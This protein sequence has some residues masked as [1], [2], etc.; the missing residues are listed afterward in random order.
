M[1]IIEIG[2]RLLALILL[3]CQVCHR[4][5]SAMSSS[6]VKLTREE[7]Y[8]QIWTT[9]ARVLAEQFDISDVGLAKACKRMGIP[10]PPRGYWRRKETGKQVKTIPL[11]PA[12]PTDKLTV[13][14]YRASHPKRPTTPRRDL[15][16]AE[17]FQSFDQPHPLVDLT[18]RRFENATVSKSGLLVS[19]AKQRLDLTVS[20]D[21]LERALRLYDAILKA[22]ERQGNEVIIGKEDS[23]LTLLRSGTETLR[24]SIEEEVETVTLPPTET[25]L[26]KPKWTWKLRTETRGKGSLKILLRGDQIEEWRSFERRFRDGAAS[27]LENTVNR[28]LTVALDYPTDRRDYL[29]DAE[30]KRKELEEHR[31]IEQLR[32]QREEEER[33]RREAERKRVEAFFGAASEWEESSRLRAFIAECRKRMTDSGI[34][35][36]VIREW[37]AWAEG[38]ADEHDPFVDGYPGDFPAEESKTN[39]D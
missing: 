32:R 15:I 35:V 23:S 6:T 10:R 30:R 8:K 24:I 18:R 13:E 28:I 9:P 33:F 27:S 39:D 29:V 26:L 20:R 22:W 36:V 17:L 3:A 2:F 16:P 1:P 12:K 37:V 31:K 7:L 4:Y 38:I 34:D 21:K 25:E 5:Y 11:P 19:T 14:F